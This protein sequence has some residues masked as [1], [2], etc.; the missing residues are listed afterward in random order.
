M[1]IVIP[2]WALWLVGLGIG[3]PLVLAILFFAY[4]GFTFMRSF[5]PPRW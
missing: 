5:R 3:V 4:M 1:S 2:K